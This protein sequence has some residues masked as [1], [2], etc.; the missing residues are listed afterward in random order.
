MPRGRG[1]DEDDK[2][3]FVSMINQKPIKPSYLELIP[4]KNFAKREQEAQRKQ[5][6]SDIQKPDNNESKN[7]YGID[8][9]TYLAKDL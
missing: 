5:T 7:S 6:L 4:L 2:I 1:G 9:S 8:W 3:K